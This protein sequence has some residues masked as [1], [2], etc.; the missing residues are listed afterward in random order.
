MTQLFRHRGFTLSR[1]HKKKGRYTTKKPPVKRGRVYRL[2]IRDIS[3][4]GDGVGRIDNFA[5]FVP[6]AAIGETIDVRIIEVKKNCAVGKK[7]E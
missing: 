3:S 5:V 6:G 1:I 7:V 2:H 4:Q